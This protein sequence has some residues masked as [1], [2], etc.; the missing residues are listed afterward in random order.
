MDNTILNILYRFDLF[1]YIL[2]IW[3]QQ[4]KPSYPDGDWTLF[5]QG[6]AWLQIWSQIRTAFARMNFN[7]KMKLMR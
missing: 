1:V 3:G 6:I 7:T 4:V 5:E 2:R